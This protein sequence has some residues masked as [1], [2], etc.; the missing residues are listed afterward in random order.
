MSE[1]AVLPPP[2]HSLRWFGSISRLQ[3]P[4][5][6]KLGVGGFLLQRGTFVLCRPPRDGSHAPLHHELYSGGGAQG[7][8]SNNPPGPN[9]LPHMRPGV[10]LQR[11]PTPHPARHRAQPST[12]SRLGAPGRAPS[13]RAMSHLFER[14][15]RVLSRAVATFL[16][17]TALHCS[18]TGVTGSLCVAALPPQAQSSTTS[19][20]EGAQIPSPS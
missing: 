18:R 19:S 1:R 16:P 10:R 5:F 12:A 2:V 15:G 11:L 7:R 13:Q 14:D 9:F 4:L 8:H 20:T 3:A 6:V 17:V